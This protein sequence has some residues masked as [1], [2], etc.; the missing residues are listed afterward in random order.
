MEKYLQ[1]T[2]KKHAIF[3]SFLCVS[4][5]VSAQSLSVQTEATGVEGMPAVKVDDTW[6]VTAGA[7][8]KFTL[9]FTEPELTE[10][11]SN[12]LIESVSCQFNGETKEGTKTD[13]NTFTFVG[14]PSNEVQMAS[15]S[16]T[17]SYNQK[18]DTRCINCHF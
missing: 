14:I 18:N 11:Q 4:S 10:N 15:F 1:Q 6:N 7:S 16:L 9:T 3:L 2:I 12:L 17:Y 8:I 5:F 13:S